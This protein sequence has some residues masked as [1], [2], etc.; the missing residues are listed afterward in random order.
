MYDGFLVITG[1]ILQFVT[2]GDMEAAPSTSTRAIKHQVTWKR[3]VPVAP[4]WQRPSGLSCSLSRLQRG[5]FH[6]WWPSLTKWT[7]LCLSV[8]PALL[9][10]VSTEAVAA[11]QDDR[12]FEDVPADRTGE[13]L[14]CRWIHVLLLKP[15]VWSAAAGSSVLVLHQTLRLTEALQRVRFYNLREKWQNK[16]I[17][18]VAER[19]NAIPQQQLLVWFSCTA[20]WSVLGQD[21]EP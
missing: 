15:A 14:L 17:S 12:L 18:E 6:P 13:I 2:K 5:W 11:W 8:C 3:L 10:T 16:H 20:C 7:L 9:Q 1:S 19:V 21:T 4:V